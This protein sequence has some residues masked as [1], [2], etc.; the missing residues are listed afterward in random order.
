VEFF[1][2][3]LTV[4]QVQYVGHTHHINRTKQLLQM[5]QIRCANIKMIKYLNRG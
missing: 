4:N 3:L 1:F 2:L 5:R